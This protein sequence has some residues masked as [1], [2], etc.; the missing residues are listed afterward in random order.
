MK[1]KGLPATTGHG[2]GAEKLAAPGGCERAKK[3]PAGAGVKVRRESGGQG[4]KLARMER[5]L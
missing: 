3:T 4:V 5:R 2:S 1:R